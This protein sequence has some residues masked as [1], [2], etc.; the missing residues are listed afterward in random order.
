MPEMPAEMVLEIASHDFRVAL[1]VGSTCRRFYPIVRRILAKHFYRVYNPYVKLLRDRHWGDLL[2]TSQEQRK[3]LVQAKNAFAT[4][5]LR[6]GP[7]YSYFFRANFH[8]GRVLTDEETRAI[9]DKCNPY[10]LTPAV[11]ERILAT[12]PIRMHPCTS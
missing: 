9:L 4:F 7:R 3:A 5:L 6:S 1:R 2:T 11:K 8:R 10:D 12:V